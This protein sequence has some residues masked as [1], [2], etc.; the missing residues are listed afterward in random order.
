MPYATMNMIN[1]AH[2]NSPNIP[3]TKGRSS[4]AASSKASAASIILPG[5]TPQALVFSDWRVYCH[6]IPRRLR[7]EFPDGK[8]ASASAFFSI[9]SISF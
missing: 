1:P 8:G 4:K 3:G 2:A 6:T 9:S 5:D 7:R